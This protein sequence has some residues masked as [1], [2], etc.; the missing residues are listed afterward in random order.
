[1]HFYGL[2]VRKR[3]CVGFTAEYVLNAMMQ[4]M[5]KAGIIDPQIQKSQLKIDFGSQNKTKPFPTS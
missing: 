4:I 5:T 3:F 1:M 2:G